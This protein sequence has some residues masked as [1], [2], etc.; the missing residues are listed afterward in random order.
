[1]KVAISTGNDKLG[2]IPNVSLPP[3]KSCA[4][5]EDVCY[6]GCYAKRPYRRYPVV[7]RAWDGN[8]EV[9]FADLG[10][11]FRQIRESLE[12]KKMRFF[13]WHVGGDIISEEYFQGM[14]DMAVYFPEKNFLCFSKQY[15]IVNDYPYEIPT[16]LIIIFSAWPGYEMENPKG[17]RV[18]W[19]QNG[20][21]TRIP[22]QHIECPGSCE[23]CG[24]CWQIN[25][26]GM[27]VVFHKH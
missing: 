14:V 5:C 24:M 21:E 6:K 8:L 26:I 20:K 23:D 15:S 2:M 19:M 13:R 22:E 9:A 27:D 18:A 12:E 4:G 16:N 25:K 3:G 7:R 10:E 1:M 11:Y 17:F